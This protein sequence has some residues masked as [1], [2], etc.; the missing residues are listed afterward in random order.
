MHVVEGHP[1]L[2]K[3]EG[4]AWRDELR[5]YLSLALQ[6]A[7]ANITRIALTTIDSAFLGHLGTE[8]LAAA[9]LAT[10]WTQVPLFSVWAMS[11][12][13][14]T[15]CGQAFGAR[16]FTLMGVWFQMAL[17]LVS[18]L[19]CF[20]VGYYW[21]LDRI[22]VRATDDAVIVDLGTRFSRILSGA[23]WPTLAYACM[24]QYL[25]AMHIVAPTTAIGSISIG[26]AILANYVLIYGAG[27]W[28]GLGFDGSAI[29]TVLASWFQP[30]SLFLYA[31]VYRGYHKQA[32][33]GW[34]WSAF[35]RDR[36]RL[37][38]RMAIPLGMIDGFTTLAN[39]CMSLI[40][41]HM[42]AEILASNAIL[43]TLWGLLWALFWGFGCATQVKVANHLGAG[44]ADAAR[45][46]SRLGFATILVVVGVVVGLLLCFQEAI[47]GI[48]TSDAHLMAHCGSVL[49]LFVLGFSVDAL[50]I[51]VTAILNGMGQMPFVSS[52]VFTGMWLVQLP[53]SYVLAIH[54]NYGFAG[55][56][57]GICVTAGF[58][59]LVLSAKYASV[60]WDRM[61]VTA[62]A[63]MAA[64]DEVCIHEDAFVAGSPVNVVV[65][66]ALPRR[67]SMSSVSRTSLDA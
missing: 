39:S 22:L 40:A 6:V 35:T 55:L 9:S 50:E 17:L 28:N 27:A 18:C 19:A 45:G 32:W 47:L 58:K 38:L 8:S 54:C 11:S 41:A 65:A 25:Q 13:L 37:F 20:V 21:C 23:I 24:R 26:L 4:F 7:L 42:G 12:S 67:W 2:Q 59:L 15:L 30:T 1:L 62:M 44:R 3:A 48:Y 43:L 29:A 51:T 36:W 10:I 61:A 66:G 46:A 64:E 53:L 60:D 5:A 16:N 52:V 14:I 33:G 56:W 34:H 63:T 57:A 49:P 31:F